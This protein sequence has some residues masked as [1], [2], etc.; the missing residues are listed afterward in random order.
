MPRSTSIPHS[1]RTILD[2]FSG[3]FTAPTF[4][5]FCALVA[6]YIVRPAARTVC[7]MLTGAGLSRTWHHSRA[8]RFFAT[9]RWSARRVGLRLAALVVAHLIGPAEP[10]LVA[11]DE[12][13]LRRRGRKV[14]AIGWWHD[15]SAAN[16]AKIGLGNSWVVAAIVV[17]LPMLSRPVA[18]P[19]LLALSVKGERTKPAMARDLI[20][21]L[22]T[23][24]PGRRIDVV[25][26]SAY[27]CRAF[28]GL[29]A[30]V[31]MTTRARSNAVFYQPAPPRTGQRGRPRLRGAR[32]GHPGDI[33]AAATWR[34]A[35][36]T[37]YGHTHTA[38]ITETTCLWYG[39]WRTQ[40]VRVIAVR[41]GRHT[42]TDRDY[43]IAI[44]TTDLSTAA[45]DIIARYAARWAIEVAFYDAK[46]ITGAGDAQNRVAKAVERTVPFTFYCQ[47]L[48]AIWY[49]LN[50]DPETHVT[51]RRQNSPWYRTKTNPCTY[52]ML[53]ALRRAI[54][55]ERF[56]Q[57][58]PGQTTP[59][60][61]Q[62]PDYA[63][64][65]A[66]S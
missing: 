41:D 33:A 19:V 66:A 14:H 21:A 53:T 48:I 34:P 57:Q 27:G 6:G 3:C 2:E 16:K 12:T 31:S 51:Q 40:T 43:G 61:I 37:R 42:G 24:F 62:D 39:P 8:H 64:I 36:L 20:D 18:L 38:S 56:T 45:Q 59:E 44:V 52:D 35:I 4:G 30:D 54:I 10:I 17:H 46:N 63:W 9:S 25:A 5:V 50:A 49:H 15:G 29:G 22:A 58:Y 65:L 11:L 23:H 60:Q 55:T 1:L 47:T 26:D 13:L 28:A 32:I 7:G